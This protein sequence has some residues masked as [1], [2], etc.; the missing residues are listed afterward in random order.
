MWHTGTGEPSD[1]YLLPCLREF[2]RRD[3]SLQTTHDYNVKV[4]PERLALSC[5]QLNY[6]FAKDGSSSF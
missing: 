1:R 3:D 4:P 6:G 2:E 5:I